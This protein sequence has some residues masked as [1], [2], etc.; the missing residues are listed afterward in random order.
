MKKITKRTV[1]VT[2]LIAAALLLLGLFLFK[3]VRDGREWAGFSANGNAYTNGLL[4]YGRITDR[5]GTTLMAVKDG[6]TTFA[7][8]KAT[9]RATLH[10]VGDKERNIGTGA[11][12]AFASDIEGYSLLN[13][14]YSLEGEGGTLA[15][16]LD[17]ELNK[18]AYK[19]LDGRSG[20]VAVMDYKTGEL[21]CMVSTP[22]FDPADPPKL[23]EDDT[24]GV[25][26]NRF[27]SASYTPGSV[28]KL[29]TLAAAAENLPDLYDR[30]FTCTGSREIGNGT[31]VCT[32]AHGE[33]KIEDALADSCNCVF[34]ELAAELGADTLARYAQRYGLT[35]SFTV[36]GIPTKAGRFE[37]SEKTSV[38]LAWS[39]VGQYND[40]INPAAMLRFVAA[41]ANG[42]RAA[43]MKLKPSVFNASDRLLSARTADALGSAM[44][45]AVYRTYGAKNFPGLQLCAKSGTAEVGGGKQPHAW[46]AGF[47]ENEEHPLAFVVV[48]ENGGW[49]SS[50]AGSVAN[51]VL[52][53]A[54][55][56]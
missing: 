43:T 31:V 30:T 38:D 28:F 6:K 50:A 35:D 44:S 21:L 33:M 17:A 22:A 51:K 3:Y 29:V 18:T 42:G 26:I 54:I 34:G 7:K 8:D 4:R 1:S 2:V 36:D 45:Y 27:L 16:T 41:I 12:S 32:K 52:Q 56:D 19:A 20:C 11:I 13:G 23:A 15:L 9:R 39:G 46:F 47:I 55:K 14:L 40:S 24:S 10:A 53:A 25:Y 37:K 48:I 49:G 5:N